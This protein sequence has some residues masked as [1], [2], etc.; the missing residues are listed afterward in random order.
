MGKAMNVSKYNNVITLEEI[1]VTIEDNEGVT[2]EQGLCFMD[3]WGKIISPEKARKLIT[4]LE[5]F[6]DSECDEWIKEHNKDID[7]E[8]EKQMNGH[9]E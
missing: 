8:L 3:R 5:T 1:T 2:E 7:K 9:V 6:Y 4:D